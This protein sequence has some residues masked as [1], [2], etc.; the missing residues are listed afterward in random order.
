VD[1]LLTLR[2]S[3]RVEFGGFPCA[4]GLRGVPTMQLDRVCCPDPTEPLT[5]R[6]TVVVHGGRGE[7]VNYS[8]SA[9]PLQL[10]ESRRVE[11]G[12]FP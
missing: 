7:P 12:G 9:G 2:L 4:A 5:Y 8:K 1:G 3:R 10:R 6:S 11:F